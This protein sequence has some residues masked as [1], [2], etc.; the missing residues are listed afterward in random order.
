M[1]MVKRGRHAR[2]YP[3]VFAGLC[4]LSS[5]AF[6]DEATAEGPVLNTKGFTLFAGYVV[7]G[8]FTDETSNQTIDLR[9]SASFGASLDIPLDDSSEFQVYY[10]HQ[11]TEFTPWPYPG[12]SDKL[13]VD[14]LQI[15]GTYFPEELGHGVYVVGGIGATRMT[16]DAAGFDPAT[17]LSM[18][19]GVGYLLPLSHYIGVRFEARGFA[20][21]VGS[22]ASVFCSGGCVAHLT[23]TAVTQGELMIG[24]SARFK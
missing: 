1:L 23:G 24:L 13:R 11:S 14:Y 2:R 20:T 22:S 6:A 15:G 4:L 9:E 21:F 8:H 16:P 19:V 7:G 3:W 18:N 12:T 17:R 5:A 10:G